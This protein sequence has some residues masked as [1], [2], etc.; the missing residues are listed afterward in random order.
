[1]LPVYQQ[2]I[3][4]MLQGTGPAVRR[5]DPDP[6][7]RDPRGDSLGRIDLQ[8]PGPLATLGGFASVGITVFL[9]VIY[10]GSLIAERGDVPGQDLGRADRCRERRQDPARHYRHQQPDQPYLAVKTL[11]NLILGVISF[12]ILWLLDVDFALFWAITIALLNYIPY[13]GSYLG[14][15]LSGDPVAWAVRS[16]PADDADPAG[17]AGGGAD[18][19]RQRA[20]S[21]AGSDGN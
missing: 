19:G 13:V 8:Q 15:R 10:A 17:S 6:V 20:S 18:L 1:M 2:N 5:R 9:V 16:S 4:A 3:D 21:R 12:S 11:I 7:D 14:G